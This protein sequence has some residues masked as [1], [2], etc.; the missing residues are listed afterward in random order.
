MLFK[1]QWDVRTEPSERDLAMKTLLSRIKACPK[2]EVIRKGGDVH[3]IPELVAKSPLVMTS[4]VLERSAAM[5]IEE[6]TSEE[7]D[8]IAAPPTTYHL[9]LPSIIPRAF[10]MHA[11]LYKCSD[12]TA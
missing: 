11:L 2:L 10:V 6:R 7:T 8:E 4:Q 9:M 5:A 12:C 1:V 3:S